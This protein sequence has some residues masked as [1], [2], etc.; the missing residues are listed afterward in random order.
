VDEQDSATT[1]CGVSQT[2]RK[3]DN[4]SCISSRSYSPQISWREQLSISYLI[5]Q[6]NA[7]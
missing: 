2:R 7:V 6:P 5:D 1:T 4:D 3:S